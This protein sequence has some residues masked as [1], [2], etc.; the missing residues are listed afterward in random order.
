LF[1]NKNRFVTADYMDIMDWESRGALWTSFQVRAEPR[2]KTNLA[3]FSRESCHRKRQNTG[4]RIVQYFQ[5]ELTGSVLKFLVDITLFIM[6]IGPTP[7][8]FWFKKHSW[9]IFY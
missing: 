8:C 1:C 7:I 5:A 3:H 9:V 6:V 2:P 4:R